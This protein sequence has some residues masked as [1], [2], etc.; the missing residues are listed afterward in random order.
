MPYAEIVT[1]WHCVSRNADLKKDLPVDV[2]EIIIDNNS[3]GERT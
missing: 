2:S 1:S 3:H